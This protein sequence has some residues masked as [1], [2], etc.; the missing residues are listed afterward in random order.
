MPWWDWWTNY[1]E[2]LNVPTR[3][4]N[5]YEGEAT[6]YEYVKYNG[7]VYREGM[8]CFIAGTPVCTLTGERPIETIQPGDRVLSQDPQT[9]EL[10][11]QTVL[12]TTL[13]P[14]SPTRSCGSAASR[15]WPRAATASGKW[16]AA[17]KWP[18]S[19]SRPPRCTA[20][21]GV[22]LENAADGEDAEAYNLIVA[23]FH[24]YFVGNSRVLVHDNSAPKPLLGPVP[25]LVQKDKATAPS[26]EAAK[27]CALCHSLKFGCHWLCQCH[28]VAVTSVPGTRG[29]VM[30]NPQNQSVP[31]P[32]DWFQDTQGVHWPRTATS[33]CL[34]QPSGPSGTTPSTVRST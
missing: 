23:E 33:P 31:G 9:G 7:I 11:F 34:G 29:P 25:G 6:Y 30:P 4:V 24:T 14:T 17:G 2:L 21:A 13:R 27:P 1:N 32:W 15:S 10:A 5:Y 18:N 20:W 12:G 8:S 3:P 28:A 22:P 26:E 16:D 19:S